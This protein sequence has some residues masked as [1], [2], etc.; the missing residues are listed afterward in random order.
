MEAI[1]DEHQLEDQSTQ[2]AHKDILRQIQAGAEISHFNQHELEV[3]VPLWVGHTSTPWSVNVLIPR[4][5][6][7]EVADAQLQQAYYDLWWMVGMS[8]A[9]TA[10]ALFLAWV[11]ARNI[12]QPIIEV[13]SIADQL[14]HG[15][16]DLQVHVSHHDE[17]GK[18]QRTMRTMVATLNRIAQ[19]ILE[20]ANQVTASSQ[21]MSTSAAQMS[22][23]AGAQAAASEEASSSMEEMVAN[24]RQ[25]TDNALQTEKIAVKAAEDARKSGDAVAEAVSAMQH[26]ASEIA[27]ID[28][29]TRQTRILSLN[30]K[31]EAAR[32]GDKGKG[33]AVVAA[34]VRALA[35]RSQQATTHI[36]TQANSGMAM[37]ENAGNMLMHLVP[38]IQRT[39]ELVQG[40]AA[41]SREQNTGTQQINHAIQ[42]LDSVTQHNS[43]TSEELAA[44]A[45]ELA[46][47][48]EQLQTTIAFFETSTNPAQDVASS[49]FNSQQGH[50]PERLPNMTERPTD[51]TGATNGNGTAEGSGLDMKTHDTL[52]DGLDDEFERY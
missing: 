14:A 50:A 29:I 6:I 32:A 30:A 36:I 18:L 4:D 39:A 52:A 51:A 38:D 34:E 44:T 9:C 37:A 26:I 42:Q 45:E 19:N 31:I 27:I 41:A 24:I 8:V 40:I 2:E 46:T 16:L 1:H 33:F 10:L 35:E 15:N 11:I 25:N 20:S 43:A 5:N 17:I 23:G 47:Q 28:D 3:F 49:G 48:A 22:Q 7:T 21:T 13:A 12:S